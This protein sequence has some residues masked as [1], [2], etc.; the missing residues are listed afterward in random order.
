MTVTSTYDHRVIQGAES[1]EFLRDAGPACSRATT[2][3]TSW[4]T[5]ASAV[6]RRSAISWCTSAPAAPSGTSRPRRW[7][8]SMLYH[9]AAAMA[10]VKAFRTHGHLAA[11]LDP[12]GSAAD[13]RPRARSRPARPHARGDGRHSRPTSSASP[14]PAALSPR[15]SPISRR[16]YCGTIA[17]EIEHICDARGAGLAAADDRVGRLPPAADAARSSADCSSGSPRSRRSSASCTRPTWARSASRSRA[18]TCWCRCSTSRSSGRRGGRA[19]RGHRHGPPRPAQRAG[20]HCRAPLRDDLRRVR[21]R[22]GRWK[23]GSSRPKGG[24]GD[25]KYHHGAEG[26]YPDQHRARPSP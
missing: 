7:R 10:L 15:R 18:S 19:R 26:A 24:T 11:Q 9:V 16:T 8:R 17:Y 20:A 23:A 1:G 3:S 6:C 4:S 5:K 13:R 21:G 25:V 22:H 2:G 14:C 12:L